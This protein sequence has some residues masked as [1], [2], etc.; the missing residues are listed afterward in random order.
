MCCRRLI[1]Y[2]LTIQ[3]LRESLADPQRCVVGMCRLQL[4]YAQG[5]NHFTDCQIVEVCQTS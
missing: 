2:M 3:Y 1:T 4:V 5:S